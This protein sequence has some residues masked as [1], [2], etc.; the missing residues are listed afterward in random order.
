MSARLS[1]DRNSIVRM[2]LGPAA[3]SIESPKLR[4]RA[5]PSA[6]RAYGLDFPLGWTRINIKQK[7][8]RTR[9]VT[10]REQKWVSLGER[11]G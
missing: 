11:R 7:R 9:R 8:L 6:L 5:W 10:S 1:A 3:G 4:R 2:P